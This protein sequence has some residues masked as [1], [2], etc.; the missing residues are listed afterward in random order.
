M[1]RIC[2][3]LAVCTAFA[4]GSLFAA[5]VASAYRN[6]SV[7]LSP[8]HPSNAEAAGILVPVRI[9]GGRVLRLVLDSGASG[10]TISSKVAR[11]LGLEES[12]GESRIGGLGEG[13]PQSSR[14]ATARRVS[15]GELELEDCAVAVVPGALTRDADGIIGMNVFEAFRIRLD[16]QAKELR[17]EA[18]TDNTPKRGTPAYAPEHLLMV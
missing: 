15:I 2:Y 7:R 5:H 3:R 6:Y 17:L 8:W 11:R 10:L 4:A 16:V 14:S 12:T 13:H 9:N 1:L 18:F